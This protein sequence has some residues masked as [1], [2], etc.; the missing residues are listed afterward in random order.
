[1]IQSKQRQMLENQTVLVSAVRGVI[2]GLDCFNEQF[3]SRRAAA[4]AA[5][6][7]AIAA[8]STWRETRKKIIKLRKRIRF[9]HV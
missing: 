3:R 4:A 1:M 9:K 7:E 8:F 6:V 5:V 2:S